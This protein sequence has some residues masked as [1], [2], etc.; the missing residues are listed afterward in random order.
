[1]KVFRKYFKTSI[2]EKNLPVSIVEDTYIAPK[3]PSRMKIIRMYLFILLFLLVLSVLVSCMVGPNYDQPRFF[4]DSQ[5]EKSLDLKPNDF[6]GTQPFSPLDFQDETLTE[7]LNTAV[8]NSP[9][10]RSAMTKLRQSRAGLR[11][12]EAA[13]LPTFDASAKYNYENESHNMG[14]ALQ[15]DYYQIGLDMA[16]EIDIFGGTR[17]RIESAEASLQGAVENLKNV[18]V[19]L[20]ADVCSVYIQLRQTEQLIKNANHNLRVQTEIYQTVK[21][22][23]DAGLTSEIAL[24]QAKYL[25]ET[26]KMSIP[27]LTYQQQAAQNALAVLVGVLP[28]RLNDM[29]SAQKTNLIQKKFV[30]DEAGLYALPADIIRRRP[31]VRVAEERLI[32][33]NAAVGAAI[34]DMFPKVS[35]SGMLGFGS[36]KFQDLVEHN[37]Y[38]YGYVPQVS[39]PIFHFGALKNNVE[40]KKAVKEEYLI[41]YEQALLGAAQEIKNALVAI[42]TEKKRNQSARTAYQKMT[43][44]SE[45]NW[46]KYR[47]GLIEYADVLDAEQRRLSAQTQMVESNGSLYQ[48]IVTYYKSIG[49]DFAAR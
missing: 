1:M 26:T 38:Q 15:E 41:A 10:I 48:N 22:Q 3:N 42:E 43:A 49:G 34:A 28:G 39:L 21:E 16:W 2:F 11:I 46:D 24:N 33:G 20:V 5:I 8:Q 12:S 7:L 4:T 9:T 35:L 40:L 19:S 31:D 18:H 23:Y 30:Y 44:V 6:H 14:L 29:L 25:V 32:A 17:R 13:L 36:L 37:S 45:L 47:R 27:R